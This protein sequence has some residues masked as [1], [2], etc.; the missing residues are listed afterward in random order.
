MVVGKMTIFEKTLNDILDGTMQGYLSHGFSAHLLA[1]AYVPV[2][3]TQYS[4]A[5]ISSFEVVGQ[6][7]L[8]KSVTGTAIT[9]NNGNVAVGSDPI[10]FG[11][12]I[13]LPLFRYFV[14]ATGLPGASAATKKLVAYADLTVGGGARE[15]VRGAL[16]FNH[17]PDGW[18]AF[19]QA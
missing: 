14:L 17:G 1:P 9:A 2:A 8:A 13:T 18:F 19:S 5:D 15:V 3:D 11:N 6:D 10:V 4:F 7:Y 16:V 12:P